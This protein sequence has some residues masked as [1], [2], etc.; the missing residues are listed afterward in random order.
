MV[1]P[2][3]CEN[4][5]NTQGRKDPGRAKQ[6]IG[7]FGEFCNFPQNYVIK[8]RFKITERV[9]LCAQLRTQKWNPTYDSLTAQYIAQQQ[10]G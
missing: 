7:K 4:R 9:N 8:I 3:S 6:R 2:V 10:R 1:L 5:R